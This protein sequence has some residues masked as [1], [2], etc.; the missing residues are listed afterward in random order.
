M[1]MVYL[2]AVFVDKWRRIDDDEFVDEFWPHQGQKKAD[3]TAETVT[4]TKSSRLTKVVLN[5]GLLTRLIL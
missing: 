4:C 5:K 1:S 2:D 3:A